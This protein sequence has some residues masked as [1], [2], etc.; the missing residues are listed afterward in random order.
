MFHDKCNEQLQRPCRLTGILA[1]LPNSLPFHPYSNEFCDRRRLIHK[2]RGR[3]RGSDDKLNDAEVAGQSEAAFISDAP[4]YPTGIDCCHDESFTMFFFID[5]TNRQSLLAITVV[6]KWFQHALNR[7]GGEKGNSNRIICIPNQSTETNDVSILASTGFFEL[8]FDH[9]SRSVLLHLL[10]ASR[11][12]SIIVVQNSNGRV[13]TPY[14]WEAIEREGTDGGVL[15]QWIERNA[16]MAKKG[17]SQS[18]VDH[19]LFDSHVVSEWKNG[20]SGLPR[21]WHFVSWLM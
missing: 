9:S 21:W 19:D 20:R 11:V 15:N 1:A 16:F 2:H 13:V 6:A 7:N 5:Y 3:R 18:K 12:P 4:I 8:P 14:G 10:N 17:I